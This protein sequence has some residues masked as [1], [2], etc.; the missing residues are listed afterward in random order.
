MGACARE[1]GDEEHPYCRV[2][3][4]A[5][6]GIHE[7]LPKMT[8][9]IPAASDVVRTSLR[10]LRSMR[11]KKHVLSTVFTNAS[12]YNVVC[13]VCL[14]HQDSFPTV[15]S[16]FSTYHACACACVCAYEDVYVYV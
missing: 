3:P 4:R 10:D 7:L 5:R 1:T 15:F 13:F 6:C 11:C 14:I 8:L 2:C 9:N 16:S 12:N